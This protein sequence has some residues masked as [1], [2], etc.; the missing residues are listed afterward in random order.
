VCAGIGHWRIEADYCDDD[1]L[2][3]E[4]KIKAIKNGV[5][6]LWDPDAQEATRSDAMFVFVPDELSREKFKEMYPDAARPRCPP[7]T[8]ARTSCGGSRP[9]ASGS[10]SIG[11]RSRSRR[12]WP[13]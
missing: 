3:Q 10:P 9:T 2:E 5:G 4:L 12:R 6:V 13:C 7:R 11:S 8:S 1:T